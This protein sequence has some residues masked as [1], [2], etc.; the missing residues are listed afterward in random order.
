MIAHSC[1]RLLL[2]IATT[3][4]HCFCIIID[5][6]IPYSIFF[7]ENSIFHPFFLRIP[8]S[9]ALVFAAFH[10]MSALVGCQSTKMPQKNLYPKYL[11]K[12]Q[13]NKWSWKLFTQNIFFKKRHNKYAK[14]SRTAGNL[15]QSVSEK[16]LKINFWIKFWN[17]NRKSRNKNRAVYCKMLW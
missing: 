3:H 8:S 17:K 2:Y 4:W 7:N 6:R 1:P 12:K 5:V 11:I 13:H 9:I 15:R 14:I 10:R 16:F